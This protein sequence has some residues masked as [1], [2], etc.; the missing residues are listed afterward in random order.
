[1]HLGKTLG[2]HWAM[3][4]GYAS[5]NPA[6][7]IRP[8]KAFG[9][10]Q[11]QNFAAL[12]LSEIP[13]FLERLSLEKDLNSVLACRMLALTWVR[14]GELRM[15]EWPEID[16]EMW[17]IPAGKMKRRREHVVP[18]SRQALSILDEMRNRSETGARFVF[19]AP[20]R[21]DRP[22]SENAILYLIARMGYRGRMTGHGW[23]SVAST[24]ANDRGYSP[25]AIERQ[26]A[27]V[28]GNRIRAAYNR[29]E[30]LPARREMLQTWADWLDAQA[31][32]MP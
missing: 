11:V 2:D 14:T 13:A 29:A 27:H 26:L 5:A 20:H 31:M 17:I 15:M 28:P 32:L 12:P 25:D 3:E 1:M 24:W 8:E 30:Y 22:M 18:L 19:P 4:N 23:R 7:A 21:A 6:A 16:G 9:R 10:A